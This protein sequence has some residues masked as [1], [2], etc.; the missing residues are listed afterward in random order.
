MSLSDTEIDDLQSDWKTI[1]QKP[2]GQREFGVRVFTRVFTEYPDY[3]KYFKKFDG[4]SVEEVIKNNRLQYHAVRFCAAL[5]GVIAVLDEMDSVNV[6]LYELGKAH[7]A[8]GVTE[9]QTEDH[10]LDTCVRGLFSSGWLGTV[11]DFHTRRGLAKDLKLSTSSSSRR[12]ARSGLALIKRFTLNFIVRTQHNIA[13]N[14]YW[15]MLV[16]MISNETA[17]PPTG[18]ICKT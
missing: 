13:I 15:T 18:R 6:L 3:L 5:N 16:R 11:S 12:V 8:R 14:S 4:Q 9:Q 17:K 10:N 7:A 1:K 2:H